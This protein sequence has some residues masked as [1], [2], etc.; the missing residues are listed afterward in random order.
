M[1][2]RSADAATVDGS[3]V[4][5][6]MVNPLLGLWSKKALLRDFQVFGDRDSFQDYYGDAAPEADRVAVMDFQRNYL[7]A[8]HQ[9]LCPTGGYSIRVKAVRARRDAVT[10]TVDFQEPGPDDIV[11]MAMTTP[12]LFLLIP[13]RRGGQSPIFRFRSVEGALLAERR[14]I[15]GKAAPD[16]G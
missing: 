15:Y 3:P 9:G 2:F 4:R 1:L 8:I 13:H 7:V 5:Y 11:T 6:Q 12:H 10:V 16:A 14:P